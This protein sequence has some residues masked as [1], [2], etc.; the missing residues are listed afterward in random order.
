[1]GKTPLPVQQKLYTIVKLTINTSLTLQIYKIVVKQKPA[2][3][4]TYKS[5]Q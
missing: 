3:P 5:R 4:N 2:A 1:M